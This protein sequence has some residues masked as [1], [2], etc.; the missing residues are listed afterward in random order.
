MFAG[1]FLITTR[2]G[3]AIPAYFLSLTGLV[4]CIFSPVVSFRRL[5]N[6]H[7]FSIFFIIL[8]YILIS[9]AWYSPESGMG[10]DLQSIAVDLVVLC[11][12][13]TAFLH[14]PQKVNLTRIVMVSVLSTATISALILLLNELLNLNLDPVGAWNVR[15][16]AAIAFGFVL[17][18]ALNY[19]IKYRM[20]MQGILHAFVAVISLAT[21]LLLESSVVFF[22]LLVALTALSFAALWESSFIRQSLLWVFLSGILMVAV[23]QMFNVL[24]EEKRPDVWESTLAASFDDGLM[25]GLGYSALS[26]PNIDCEEVEVIRMGILCTFQHPHNL[27]VSVIYQ[28]GLVGFLVLFA[29]YLVALGGLFERRSEQRWLLGGALFYSAAIFM[30]DGSLIVANM[31]FVW[32][33][34]WLPIFLIMREEFMAD[35]DHQE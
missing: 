35:S 26:T 5:R 25:F 15:S 2:H 22:A 32:L 12:V 18:I 31:D 19:S 7:S 10:M 23:L 29:L 16:V 1:Y 33:I 6:S 4:S 8:L 21:V 9:L 13:A 20:T 27:F 24:V 14:I 28:L 3:S 34:F 17:L 11:F 30:F